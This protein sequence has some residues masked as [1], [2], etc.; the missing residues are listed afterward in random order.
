MASENSAERVEEYLHSISRE[1]PEIREQIAHYLPAY[2]KLATLNAYSFEELALRKIEKERGSNKYKDVLFDY[3]Q[4]IPDCPKPDHA[5]KDHVIKLENEPTPTYYCKKCRKKFSPNYNSISSNSTKPPRVWMQIL[6]C[7]IEGYPVRRICS[8][9][10]ISKS[11]YYKILLKLFYAMQVVLDEMK[12]YGIIRCDNTFVHS[13]F[14]GQNLKDNDYPEDSLFDVID[15]IPRTAR[16][17]G[18]GYSYGA[19]NLNSICIFTAIDDHGHILAK[20]AGIGNTT[21]T[22]L[23]RAVPPEQ[24]LLTVPK[25]DPFLLTFQSPPDKQ[26]IPKQTVLVSDKEKAIAKYAEKLGV[27]HESHIYRRKG[28]QVRLAKD[29]H[30]IQRVNYLHYRLKRFFAEHSFVSSKYLPGYLTLFSFIETTHCTDEAIERLFEVIV[31]PGLGKSPQYYQSLYRTPNYIAEW[32][33]DGTALE[34]LPY[35]QMLA[36]YLYS[37]MRKDLDKGEKSPIKMQDI[38]EQTGYK[39]DKT[40]RR[41][42]KDITASG[43][44]KLIYE[45][46][47]DSYKIVPAPTTV[48]KKEKKEKIPKEYVV[49]YNELCENLQGPI[50]NHWTLASFAEHVKKEGRINASRNTMQK[51]FDMIEADCLSKYKLSVLREE[52]KSKRRNRSRMDRRGD[53]INECYEEYTRLVREYRSKNQPVPTLKELYKI[54]A[55]SVKLSPNQVE[56]NLYAKRHSVFEEL[57]KKQ[58]TGDNNE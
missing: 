25:K 45:H 41:A 53:E 2:N 36:A 8:V 35:N 20:Y 14:K 4:V 50:N 47:S 56:L 26:K 23:L 40:V 57:N 10:N 12:L 16:K 34:N 37:E 51:Y 55:K 11:T 24:Y 42:Y 9:C 39:S 17:R 5:N 28:T 31:T 38:L 7:L 44:L 18:G 27:I 54:I 48:R 30:D 15:F 3:S 33:L 58:H 13:N 22:K 29:A 1:V 49:L 32:C 52:S 21:A 6:L 46:I 19:K 43:A